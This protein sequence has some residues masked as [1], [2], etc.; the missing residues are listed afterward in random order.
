MKM[1]PFLA[2]GHM[3]KEPASVIEYGLQPKITYGRNTWGV[4]P[5]YGDQRPSVKEMP[6][7]AQPQNLRV[8]PCVTRQ[9]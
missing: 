5:G 7:N 2:E 4:A 6:Q 3:H 9:R 1:E 8:V